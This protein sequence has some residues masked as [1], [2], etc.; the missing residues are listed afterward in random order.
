MT[1]DAV[2]VGAG[3]IGSSIALELSRAGWKVVVVDRAGAAGHGS[4]SAS[5]AVIRFSYSTFDSVALAWES[6]HCWS[7]WSEH[8]GCDVGQ[9]LA[10]FQRS[11]FVSLDSGQPQS[12]DTSLLQR[13]GVPFEEWDAATLSRRVP[14]LDVGRYGPPARPTDD[15]FWADP[16]GQLGAIF[17]PD[18]GYVDDPS[19]AAQN[20]AAAAQHFGARFLLNETVT[21]VERDRGRVSGVRLAG[22]PSLLAPVVVNAAGPWSSRLNQLAGVGGDFSVSVQPMRAEVHQVTAPAGFAAAK[23]LADDDLGTYVRPDTGDTILVG[24]LEPACDPLEWIDDP[25][26]ADPRP[27][28]RMFELQVTRAARR[29]PELTVPSRPRGVAGVYDVAQDWTP[30][31]DRTALSGFYVAMGTSGNQFKNAPS[32]GRL[33][34]LIIDASEHGHDH[35]AEPLVFEGVHTGLRIDLASFSRRREVSAHSARSV[36]G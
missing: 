5:S 12:R 16:T 2:I 18:G 17:V 24:G 3:V 26:A 9:P 30:I 8:L 6:A 22:G 29:I 25:D 35:D 23:V 7:R 11:G 4:T 27:T 28:A 20:L 21:G 36:L 31:Y 14:G 13:A 10:R 33:M 34:S 15:R 19:L 1:A 32:V